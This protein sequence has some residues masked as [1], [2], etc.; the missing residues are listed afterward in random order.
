MFTTKHENLFSDQIQFGYPPNR[1]DLIT[2]MPGVDFE[3]CYVSRIEVA[4]DGLSLYFIDLDNLKKNKRAVG[5]LQDLADLE[6]LE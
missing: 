3:R 4:V 5:R 2:S 6:N 1:L